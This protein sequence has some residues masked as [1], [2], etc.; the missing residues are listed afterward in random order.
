MACISPCPTG[1]IDNWRTVPKARAYAIEEQLTLGRAAARAHARA[2]GGRRRRAEAAAAPAAEP[3]LAVAARGGRRRGAV[4]QRRVRRD[5]CR[6]GRPRTPTP[7]CTGRRARP[8]RRWSATSTA[9]RRA[10]TTRRTTSCSTS[11]R[12]R[13]RCSKASRSASCR[14]AS[15]R[16]GR[17]HIARQY[18]VASPRNGERPGYNNVS[19]TVK[20]VTEDHQGRP[21]RG[22]AS[23]YLCD[24]QG[25]RHGAGDRPVRHELPD[26]EPS[27][28]R[29][30]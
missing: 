7:T 16:S 27:A 4:Q 15:T 29:T 3:V 12:C 6:R 24:L 9:P 1:S 8:P 18:S 5:A 20:R 30:S 23:N 28:A 2:A 11:A 25:R 21:V 17:P 26:A 19:L 13:S 10:S 22:V 14:P